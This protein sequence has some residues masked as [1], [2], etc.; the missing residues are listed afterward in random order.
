MDIEKIH[1]S[2]AN[3]SQGAWVKNIPFAEVGDLALKVRGLFNADALRVR[4]EYLS[5][6]TEEE[7]KDLPK[8]KADEMSVEMIVHAIVSDWNLKQAGEPMACTE[9]HRRA[10]FTDP[11]IGD[12]MRAAAIYAARNVALQGVASIEADAKN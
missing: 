9:A 6:L 3:V 12:V 4:E 8:D 1:T 11:V 10:I 5:G 2:V 7:R